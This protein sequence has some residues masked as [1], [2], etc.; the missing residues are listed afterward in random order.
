MTASVSRHHHTFRG[1]P[2]PPGLRRLPYR[3]G[4]RPNFARQWPCLQLDQTATEASFGA[5]E[6]AIAAF[7]GVAAKDGP[8]GSP[9]IGFT[10]DEDMARGQPEAF[11]GDGVWIALRPCGS[12]HLSLRP[13]WAQKVV[14]RGLATVHP[15]AR[16]MAGAVPPQSLVVYAPRDANELRVVVRICRAAYAYA[17]GR[18]GSFI[19]PDTRW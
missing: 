10:L 12:I 19:L 16:Y 17:V 4:N 13:E 1:T 14:N 11:L 7:P 9:G 6:V 3:Q 5:L 18:V 2:V 8:F 15:F